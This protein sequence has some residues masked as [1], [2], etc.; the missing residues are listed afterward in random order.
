VR[1]VR[2]E[3][4]NVEMRKQEGLAVQAVILVAAGVLVSSSAWAQVPIPPETTPTP[5]GQSEQHLAYRRDQLRLV[6]GVLVGAVKNGAAQLSRQWQAKNPNLVLLTGTAQARGFLL[7]GYGAFFDVEI[8]G[9]SQSVAWSLVTMERDL[10]VGNALRALQ[11]MVQAISD[12]AVRRDLSQALARIELQVTPSPSPGF[13]PGDRTVRAADLP[14]N[15]G[16][17]PELIGPDDQYTAAV[18]ST[19]VDAM[20]EHGHAVG[21]GPD[22]WLTVAARD[23][24]GPTM[25]GE[26]YNAVTIVLSIRGRDLAA[27]REGRL[28]RDEARK[29]VVVREF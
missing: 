9:V 3:G 1:Q 21:V 10:A 19:L 26:I 29:A 18:K 5:A 16:Q 27:F 25:P 17:L 15:P 6:E 20:I 11:Q 4:S 24:E 2:K 7:D 14:E 28:T 13:F 12:P 8:P 23:A 22:E